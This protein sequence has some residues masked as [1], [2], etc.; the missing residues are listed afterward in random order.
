MWIFFKVT[1]I[2]SWRG[3]KTPTTLYSAGVLR[4]LCPVSTFHRVAPLIVPSHGWWGGRCLWARPAQLAHNI[5]GDKVWRP[6]HTDT[7]SRPGTEQRHAALWGGR[8]AQTTLLRWGKSHIWCETRRELWVVRDKRVI[9]PSVWKYDIMTAWETGNSVA[10]L[11]S[12]LAPDSR[13]RSGFYGLRVVCPAAL[14]FKRRQTL[15]LWL[16]GTWQKCV[17]VSAAA[18]QRPATHEREKSL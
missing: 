6:G 15:A 16:R 3:K 2:K 10:A 7:W 12:A 18:E 5:Q 11:I 9:K 13:D 4:L 1:V 17:P 8:G 14:L